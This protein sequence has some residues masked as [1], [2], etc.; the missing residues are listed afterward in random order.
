MGQGQSGNNYGST[1]SLYQ[2]LERMRFSQDLRKNPEDYAE[3]VN[4]RVDELSKEIFDK[5]RVA[6]QK[7]HID[8]GRYMDMDHNANFYKARAGDVDNLT[9]QIAGNNERI[10]NELIRDKDIT[11]RQFEINEWSNYNKLETLFFLQLFFISTLVLA[12][13]IYFHKTG[14]LNNALAALLTGI[15]LT[16]IVIVGIY[17]SYYTRRTRDTRL[18]HRRYFGKTEPAKNPLRCDKDGNIEFDAQELIP[19]DVASCASDLTKRFT[20]WQ[21]NLET[22]MASFQEGENGGKSQRRAVCGI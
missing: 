18:W 2:D 7:A 5:K 14:V 12:I 16:V 21:D 1:A 19:K 4:T 15:L 10:K 20:S 11:K 17:R 8:L 3:Y 22:Q 9:S 6:F 13:I